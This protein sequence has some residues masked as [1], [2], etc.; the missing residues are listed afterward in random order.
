MRESKGGERRRWRREE[1]ISERRG[2]V[3][4]SHLLSNIY[5]N[6]SETLRS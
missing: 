1:R 6:I 2:S 5:M 4:E 3:I